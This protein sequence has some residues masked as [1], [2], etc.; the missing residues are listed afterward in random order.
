V[1]ERF[2]GDDGQRRLI[3]TLMTHRVIGN[4]QDLAEFL[5]ASG[6]LLEVQPGTS[7]IQQGDDSTDVFFIVAGAAEVR[8]NVTTIVAN[9]FAGDHVGEMAAIEP[10]QPRSATV[11]ATAVTVLLKVSEPAFT[12]AANRFP[13][14]WRALAATLSRRLEQRN[15]L[16]AAARQ[17]VKVFIMSSVEALPITDLII[18]N[19][20]HDPFLTVAWTHG[21]FKASNYTLD[22]LEVQLDD[23]DFAVA[24]AHADDVVITRGDEWP[25]VR[26]NVLL[27]LGMFIGRLGRRRAFLMEPRDMN[28]R[29]P[30]DLTG[31]TTIPYRYR[32]GADAAALIAP[33]CARLRER[34]LAAGVRE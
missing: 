1:I 22:D 3:E 25:T 4:R 7:F 12:E 14:M 34:I 33:A 2:Q 29:L 32:R 20:E 11:T 6:E 26:D 19:F 23:S 18:Q 28:L 21:V 9:R 16:V 31:L 27:E 30:S 24:V 15:R 5:V 17:R 13:T 8:V 10:T